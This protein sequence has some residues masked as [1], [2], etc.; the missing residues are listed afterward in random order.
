MTVKAIRSPGNRM[1]YTANRITA[2]DIARNMKP[3]ESTWLPYFFVLA[4]RYTM[5]PS[6]MK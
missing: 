2:L 1:G 3:T 4:M 5:A 6:K